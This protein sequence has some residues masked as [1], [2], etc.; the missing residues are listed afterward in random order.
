MNKLFVCAIFAALAGCGS[1]LDSPPSSGE[2]VQLAIGKMDDSSPALHILTISKNGTGE[3][4]LPDSHKP[5]WLKPGRYVTRLFCDRTYE[6]QGQQTVN[7]GTAGGLGFDFDFTV[8]AGYTYTLDCSITPEH[9]QKF[10][11]YAMPLA[12]IG[13]RK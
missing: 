5:L 3:V 7:I 10:D 4:G 2:Y 13:T 12:L 9:D 8:E 1:I 6:E 11:L